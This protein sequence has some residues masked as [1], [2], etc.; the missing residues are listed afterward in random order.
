M[1]DLLCFE[2]IPYWSVMELQQNVLHHFN[3]E[4]LVQTYTVMQQ[5]DIRSESTSELDLV[6]ISTK[7]LQGLLHFP[8]NQSV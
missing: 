2:A 7:V 8:E 6:P 3:L 5:E 1:G 4:V